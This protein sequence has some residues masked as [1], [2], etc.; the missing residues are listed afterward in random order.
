MNDVLKTTSF[1]VLRREDQLEVARIDGSINPK[2]GR[3]ARWQSPVNVIE[4]DDD[5]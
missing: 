3:M 4:A 2:H 1:E 5:C